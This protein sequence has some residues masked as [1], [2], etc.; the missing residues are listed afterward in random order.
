MTQIKSD[1]SVATTAG[2][3]M[4]RVKLEHLQTVNS[5][6]ISNLDGLRLAHTLNSHIENGLDEIEQSVRAQGIRFKKLAITI[7]TTDQQLGGL[8]K[9]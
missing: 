6:S 4:A 5:P 9:P 3:K 2:D 1:T 8:F 7:E